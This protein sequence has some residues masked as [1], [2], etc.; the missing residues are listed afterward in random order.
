MRAQCLDR[1]IDP[2]TR[3]VIAAYGWL[4]LF[5]D[6]PD[7]YW[8]SIEDA[9]YQFFNDPHLAE[10]YYRIALRHHRLRLSMQKKQRKPLTK[11]AVRGRKGESRWENPID[12]YHSLR[13]QR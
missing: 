13:L 11:N 7:Q 1:L 5:K 12:S 10:Q 8:V 3:H 4:R 2:D 9:P 6:S